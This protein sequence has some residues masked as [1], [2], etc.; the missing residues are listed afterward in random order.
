MEVLACM[1]SGIRRLGT[2]DHTRAYPMKVPKNMAL[3]N[4]SCLGPQGAGGSLLKVPGAEPWLV[5]LS[6]LDFAVIPFWSLVF[7][8]L[9]C[10]DHGP[11]WPALRIA[12]NSKEDSVFVFLSL[13]LAVNRERKAFLL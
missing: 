3:S 11:P 13:R 4:G 7:G 1:G 5:L 12:V 10:L 9:R 6:L 2:Q 8:R